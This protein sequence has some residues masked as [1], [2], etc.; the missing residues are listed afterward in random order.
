MTVKHRAPDAAILEH[1]RKRKVEVQCLE[2]Q[3]ELEDKGLAPEEVER[4]VDELRQRLTSQNRHSAGPTAERGSLKEFQTHELLA[5]KAIDNSRFERA[6]GISRDFVPGE[7]L[8]KE[9]QEERRIERQLEKE[10]RNEELAE[11]KRQYEEGLEKRKA[12]A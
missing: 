7:S 2:L 5:A 8:N 9:K 12:E 10:R 3:D 1:D 11:R 4:Q 6:F